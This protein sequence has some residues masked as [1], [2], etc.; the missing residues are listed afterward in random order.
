M[1]GKLEVDFDHRAIVRSC[2]GTIAFPL[3]LTKF[4]RVAP[5][6]SID[7][8]DTDVDIMRDHL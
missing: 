7:F 3:H 4:S 2:N 6:P 1:L 8:N 5:A